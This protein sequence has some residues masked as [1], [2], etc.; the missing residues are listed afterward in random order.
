[1][2]ALHR[3]LAV[4]IAIAVFPPTFAQTRP[5]PREVDRV[6]AVV[7]TD[8][9]TANELRARTRTIERQLRMQ[10]I[11]L[12][13]A[14]V[15]E[16]QVLERLIL[17][18]ALVQA[19][20]EQGFR[21]DDAQLDRAIARIAEGSQLTPA[22]LRA[23]VESEGSSFQRFR[24]EVRDEILGGRL[25]EREV[26]ARIQISEADVDAFISEQRGASGAPAEFEIAQILLR[27]P[28]G[29]SAEQIERQRARGEDILRQLRDGADFARLAA[30]FS[31]ASDALSGGSL[32]MRRA[33]RLPQ[34]FVDAVDKLKAGEIAP[35]V[36]SPNGFHV[37]KLVARRDS[38]GP[39][40]D[41]PVVQTRVRHILIRISELVSEGEATKRL[42][43]IRRRIVEGNE[44]FADLARQYSADGSA[45][46][47][48]DLGLIYPGDTVPE[49]ERAMNALQ[50]GQV[51]EPVRSPF[52][53]HLI[54]VTER[55]TDSASPDRI[56]A[57]ARQALRERR[58][59]ETTQDWLRQ[60][61]DRTYVEYR[62]R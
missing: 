53:L 21:V 10:R 58:I 61:R 36:R 32:G 31:D 49:F 28:E 34:L 26:D 40:S 50:P 62:D 7:N 19:A 23:Q 52:G 56:R 18:R 41:V 48:G 8:V 42:Q 5:A 3:L 25:K 60:V 9:I 33:D 30:A 12:P 24:E 20:R 15:L 2:T 29:A 6:V 38:G 16:K 4:A 46:R 54:E 13:P 59:E 37:L 11:E 1:M 17:D 35:L 39:L 55:R 27:I 14:D 22:Q 44:S 57:L 47:G 51:S 45:G 43:Q